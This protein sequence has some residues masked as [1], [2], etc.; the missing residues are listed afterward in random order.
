MKL[1]L[2]Q[3]FAI[4]LGLVCT[5][6][7]QAQDTLSTRINYDLTAETAVGTGDYT[8]FQL[9]A[10]R[11]H[12]LATRANTAYLRGAMNIEH[13]LTENLTLSS[14][15]DAIAAVHADQQVYLQQLTKIQN[16]II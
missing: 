11:Y 15:V 14:C 10:N 4:F 16:Q 2:C 12:T 13:S 6:S 3:L 8:A 7:I 9:T 1:R 5:S